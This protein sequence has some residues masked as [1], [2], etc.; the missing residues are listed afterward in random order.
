MGLETADS[1]TVTGMEHRKI[2]AVFQE[3]RLCENLSAFANIRMVRKTRLWEK[4]REGWEEISR[5]MEA[6]GLGGCERQPVREMSGGM[7]QRVALLR[8]AVRQVGDPGFG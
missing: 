4:D 8:G 5:G 3:P 7:R 1:G 2:S 6:L